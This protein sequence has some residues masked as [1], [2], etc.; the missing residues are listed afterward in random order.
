MILDILSGFLLFFTAVTILIFE[1]IP[2]VGN[3]V[4]TL[5]KKCLECIFGGG[6]VDIKKFIE[7]ANFPHF[8]KYASCIFGYLQLQLSDMTSLAK[9]S[10][11]LHHINL[12]ET[13]I[14]DL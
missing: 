4:E 6:G 1:P 10:F 8:L 13:Y 2:F 12:M 3:I 9:L 5:L 7:N 14:I 11:R